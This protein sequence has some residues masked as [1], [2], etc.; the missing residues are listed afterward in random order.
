MS[1]GTC[2]FKSILNVFMPSEY[3]QNQFSYAGTYYLKVYD[4][5]SIA[6]D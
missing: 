2:N 5:F 3:G 4:V 1:Y 6:V